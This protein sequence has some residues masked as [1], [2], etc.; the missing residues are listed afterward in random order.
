MK[1]RHIFTLLLLLAAAIVRG[2]ELTG[3]VVD[4]ASGSKMP[5]VF[6]RNIN[7]KQLGITDKNG[8]FDI[9]AETGNLLIFQ[10]PGYVSDTLY[11]I[12]MRPKKIRLVA[13]TIALRE[14]RINA[15]R[16]AFDPRKEYPEVYTKSKFYVL[17]PTSW[18]GKEAR[19]ARRL[20]RYFKREAEERKVDAVFTKAYVGSIVPLKGIELEDFMLMYRP[21]YDQVKANNRTSLAVYIND[22]YKKYKALPP[23]QRKPQ[24]LT[25]G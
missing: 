20:K 21:T 18:F 13:Q 19:D 1:T 12:D 9:P 16:P 25:G 2:Q 4:D 23:D 11:V 17:S 24:P 8:R 3:S 22:C 10:C 7:N 6:I 15:T 5:D 14:V